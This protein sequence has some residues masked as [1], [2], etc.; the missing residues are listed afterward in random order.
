MVELLI[1]CFYQR[2]AARHVSTDFIIVNY[3]SSIV[4]YF[5]TTLKL[6]P[7]TDTT[8]TPAGAAIVALSEETTS[9]ATTLPKIVLTITFLPSAPL[10]TTAPLTPATTTLPA[11]MFR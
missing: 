2:D 5:T 8:T 6:S 7:S 10:T 3:Q 11:A 4:N 1:L 9:L